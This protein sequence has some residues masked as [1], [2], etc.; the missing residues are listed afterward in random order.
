MRGD[1]PDYPGASQITLSC[2]SR[3][4]YLRSGD[5][6]MQLISRTAFDEEKSGQ[7]H[8]FQVNLSPAQIKTSRINDSQDDSVC[9]SSVKSN[10]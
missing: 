2:G 1:Y 5:S 8:S 7:I 10:S 9:V 4:L 3:A 6:R